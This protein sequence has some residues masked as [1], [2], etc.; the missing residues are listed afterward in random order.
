MATPAPSLADHEAQP[1]LAERRPGRPRDARA[2]RAILEATLALLGETGFAG[3]TVDAVAARAGVSKATIYRR[4]ASKEAL[5]LD[6]WRECVEY[7]AL[8]DTG[9]LRGDLEV[10]AE[11][12]RQSAGKATMRT[13][14][15]QMLAAARVDREVAVAYERFVTERR[16]PMGEVL[17]RAQARGELAPDADLELIHDLIVG[18]VF[19]RVLVSGAPVNA[20]TIDAVVEL[21]LR[22]VTTA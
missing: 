5:V 20:A 3:M 15:P 14:L 21:V 18:P 1:P 17:R 6:A 11:S 8:P 9:S 2:D 12:L 16:A 22:A 4:W 19:Y 13:V 10:L 7:P